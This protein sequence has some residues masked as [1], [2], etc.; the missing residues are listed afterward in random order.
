MQTESSIHPALARSRIFARARRE[1]QIS[2]LSMNSDLWTTIFPGL[3]IVQA[4]L[5]HVA[6]PVWKIP[7][8]MLA[9]FVL[10]WLQFYSVA[11][12]EQSKTRAEDLLNK[13]WRPLPAGLSSYAGFRSRSFVFGASYLVL[14]TLLGAGWWCLALASICFLHSQAWLSRLW[15]A[16]S[17]LPALGTLAMLSALWR[18]IAPFTPEVW[19]WMAGMLVLAAATIHV[20]DLRDLDGDRAVGRRTLPML[21]G[22]RRTRIGLAASF[23]LMPI[24]GRWLMQVGPGSSGAVWLCYAVT[25]VLCWRLAWRV[26]NLRGAEQDH[27]TYRCWEYWYTA[28]FVSMIFCL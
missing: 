24:A 4:A 21:I 14:G 26:W 8:L 10:S 18:V 22:D 23:L 6:M 3:M 27:R 11:L 28:M 12:F 9:A 19:R 25:S 16:K 1:W 5:A 15:W 17:L 13:P 7:L 20:Q 2:Y